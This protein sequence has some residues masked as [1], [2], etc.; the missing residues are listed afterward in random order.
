MKNYRVLFLPT[1]EDQ[2][3]KAY[4]WG[5][6]RWGKDLADSWLRAVYEAVFDRLSTFPLSCPVAPES[7]RLKREVRHYI[8]G[9]YRLLFEVRNTDIIVLRLTGP[10]NNL[11]AELGVEE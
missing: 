3:L 8:L 10:F 2:I 6:E 7:R 5:V 9:R 4:D 11:E 1:A